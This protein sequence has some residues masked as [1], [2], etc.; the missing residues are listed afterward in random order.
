[1]SIRVSFLM[2]EKKD[3]DIIGILN[4]IVK[5]HRGLFFKEALRLGIDPVKDADI[6][7]GLPHLDQVLHRHALVKKALRHYIKTRLPGEDGG[8]EEGNGNGAASLAEN[9]SEAKTRPS[10]GRTFEVPT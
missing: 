8:G 4:G 2:D 1:M 9:K 10:F 6:Y 3:D 7:E 5:P